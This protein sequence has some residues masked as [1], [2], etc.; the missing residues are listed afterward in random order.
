MSGHSG[1]EEEERLED[2]S[3]KV[4]CRLHWTEAIINMQRHLHTTAMI[5]D[6][7][8]WTIKFPKVPLARLILRTSCTCIINHSVSIMKKSLLHC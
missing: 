1:E 7:S 4:F 3:V 8:S 6:V 2:V 5:R